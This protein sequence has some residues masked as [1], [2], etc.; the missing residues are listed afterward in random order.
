MEYGYF[1]AQ[2]R[3]YVIT[4]PNTPA[5][6]ANY[7]GSPAYGAIVTNNAGGYSFVKSGAAGRVLRYRFNE[8]DRP[9]RYVYLRDDGD[10]DYWSASWQ[11]VGKS[12][13]M[14]RNECRHG[15]GYT[16]L[17]AK[18][19]GIQS[20]VDYYVPKD[21]S[22]EV[23]HVRVTNTS[24]SPRRISAFGY[25]EFTNE[26]HYEQDTVNLQYTQ[27][28]TKTEYENN[29]IRQTIN[30][31]FQ[32]F[33]QYMPKTRYFG[34]AGA[35]VKTYCGD[36]EHFL[37]D[38]SGY[39]NPL[40]VAQGKLNNALNYCGNACGALHTAF[41]L[42][43]GECKTFTFILGEKQ[44][45]E[46]RA[47]M[48]RY[49]EQSLPGQEIDALKT[50]WHG[51][52]TNLSVQTPNAHFNNMLNTWNAYNCFITFYWSRAASL[53]YCG[54][55]NGYGYRDTV[56]DIQGI[57][58]L[59][60]AEARSKLV[61]MLS[62][63]VHHGA[64]LP[65]VK[66][67]HNPGHE[68]TPDDLTY[69][70]ETGHPSYRADDMMWVFPTVWKYIAE[71]GDMAFLDEVVPYA[72]KGEDTVYNHLR[73]AIDFTENHL[74]IHGL[75]AGLHADW[76]D[77]LRMGAQGISVFV[78]FQFYYALD[79][80][81]RLAKARGEDISEFTDKKVKYGHIIEEKCWDTDRFVRGITEKDVVI[82]AAGDP[83]ANM[84]LNPQSW[85]VIS[86]FAG[87]ERGRAI[88]DLVYQRLNTPYGVRIMDP[89][90]VRHAFEG[91][92]ALLFNPSTK[93]N[94]GI[95]LHTQGWIILAEALLGRGSRAFEYYL[96]SCPAAQNEIAD[97]R[98][99][100]PYVY[101][102]FTESVDSPNEGRSHVHWLTGTASTVMVAC[103]EGILGLR[104]DPGGLR[105]APA[106]PKEWE[107]FTMTKIFRGKTM[108]ITVKNPNGKEGG[109][110]KVILNGEA[111]GDNYIPA[112][113]LKDSNE[114]EVILQ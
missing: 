104:P 21:A 110:P 28:I 43:A 45:G 97:I 41:E 87:A 33:Y 113:S 7:L 82:G 79:I 49:A 37:A 31:N 60:P 16:R 85:A 86:G 93:E 19:K 17:T 52:F 3:E 27:F 12:L 84:W 38:Y 58:H 18:Y 13:D 23:W 108:S 61:F 24:D 99:V 54:Q 39:H 102:Q 95:F 72:D 76:N 83:E 78:A 75:P 44:D 112:A 22:H 29:F 107:G 36:R 77:C 30:G 9:G 105:L 57:I 94:G 59:D 34:L 1:D 4:K 40:G 70:Q 26:P 64:G 114:I 90:Y 103:V 101:S 15:T 51:K 81:T 11:P 71:T 73:K 2:A 89:A 35:D 69:R 65:L 92:L 109:V 32:A 67:T 42:A 66:Y 25:A 106:I 56:Q 55:R 8:Q 111:L 98:K 100:E 88:L 47:L 63:Q 74:G 48:A 96:E 50:Y 68:N 10:G 53:A 5:A 14:Y 62:A 91:A 6:W 20:T 80:M 46:F